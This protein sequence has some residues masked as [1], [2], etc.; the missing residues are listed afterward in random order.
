MINDI[1]N[2]IN[3]IRNGYEKEIQNQGKGNIR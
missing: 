1:N 3:K 2:L